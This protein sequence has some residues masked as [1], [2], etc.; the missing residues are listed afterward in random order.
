MKITKCYKYRLR[1]TSEQEQQFLQFAGCRRFVWNWAL[2]RKQD[3]FK[4]TGKTITYHDLAAELVKLKKQPDTAFLKDS[5]A[6][7]LQQVMMDLEKAFKN[8]FSK[9]AKFPK[10]KSKHKCLPAFRF[11]QCATVNGND[12]YLPKIGL[13]RA[14]I[15]RPLE[16][17]IKSATVKQEADGHWYCIFVSHSDI[18]NVEPSCDNPV[19]IDLGLDTFLTFS[20][21]KKVA[22]PKFFRKSQNKLKRLQ[23][24][25][26]RCQ[27]TSKERQ[28]AKLRVAKYH[29]RIANQR[30]DFLHKASADI[31]SKHDTICVE[32]LAIS[33]LTKT[34]L[35]GHSKSWTDAACGNFLR[36]LDYKS[37]WNFKQLVE[38]NRWFPSSKTCHVC[39]HIQQLTL[40]DR[41]W[42]CDNCKTL[43]DRDTNA[44]INIECEGLRTLAAGTTERQNASGENVRL[45]TASSSR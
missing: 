24:H 42:M 11:P 3:H 36:M 30:N 31:I 1:P 20:D 7:M 12:V 45:A 33:A 27:K 16:G 8:F 38:I 22:P 19:G 34:K 43:H 18:P 44:A 13:V 5:N 2:N 26:A 32:D 17:D 37:L 28:K 35:R 4:E 41:Q 6:Q 14:S 40:S 10:F 39:L 29:A 21:G 15:H 25:L 9:R 23:R